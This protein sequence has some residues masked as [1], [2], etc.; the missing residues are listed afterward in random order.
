MSVLNRSTLRRLKTLHQIPSVWEGDR[1]RLSAGMAQS[2]ESDTQEDG[3]C[4]VW[5]D[6]VEGMVRAMDMVTPETGPEAMVRALLRAMEYPHSPAKPARP[7]KIIVRDREV[8]FYLRGILQDLEIAIDYVPELPL[9]DELFRSFQEMSSTRP[10]KLP[11]EYVELLEEKAQEIWEDAPWEMLADHQIISIEINQ[12]DIGTLYASVMGM[13]GMEYGILLY[14][15]LDSLKRFR[16]SVLAKESFEELEE[17]FLGQDCLFMT[18]EKAEDSFDEDEDEDEIDLSDL[19]LSEIGP[20]F[21]NVHPL[22]GMRPFLYEEEAIAVYFALEALHRFFRASHRQLSDDKFPSLT[23]RFRIPTP[24]AVEPKQTLSVKVETVPEV[25]AELFN[26]AQLAAEDEDEEEFDDEFDD[27]FEDLTVPLRDD[28]IPKGSFFSLG[29]MTWER[30][31]LLRQTAEHYQP[32]DIAAAGE[33][34]P[35]ILIQTSR[36]KA[37]EL[38]EK[39][40]GAGGLKGVCFNPGEDPEEGDL[41]DLGIL[42]TENGNMYLF[43]EFT[44]DDP[45]HIEA[46]RK[47]DQRC[48]KTKGYCGVIIARGLKG[49]SKGNPQ[50][51]D[52]MALFEARSLSSEELGL[53]MLQLIPQFGF[54]LE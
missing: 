23:K 17:A 37:K 41:Y 44:G 18:F 42:Q 1:R 46:R 50:L 30:L 40:Q 54:E 48:Q 35:V 53:G 45:V 22:E 2:L 10:P 8:Q 15:S 29:M 38:I 51:G 33:G 28:L 16:A 39:I 31:D 11:P 9:V 6:G 12:W 19:A 25:A 32:K 20:S 43:G 34:L 4:I 21:G 24:P 49:A 5:L 52:M 47:W 13:L 7:Q 27:E 14:R 3:D 26:M 36:P